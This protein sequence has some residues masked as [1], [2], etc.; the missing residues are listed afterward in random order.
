M[1]GHT[2]AVIVSDNMRS[3]VPLAVVAYPGEVADPQT[4]MLALS[5]GAEVL[6]SLVGAQQCQA[7]LHWRHHYRFL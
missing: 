7:L 5:V 2:T 3:S 1:V 4:S 6:G